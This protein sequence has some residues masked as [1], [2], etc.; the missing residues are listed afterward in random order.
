MLKAVNIKD[1]NV[2]STAISRDYYPDLSQALTV[3]TTLNYACAE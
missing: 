1:I 3:E 2:A